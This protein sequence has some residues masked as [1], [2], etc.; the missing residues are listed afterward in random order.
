N[1]QLTHNVVVVAIFGGAVHG[2][3]RDT[4]G[5]HVHHAWADDAVP[6]DAALLGEVIM[7]RAEARQIL[8]RKAV[9]SVQRV[10]HPQIVASWQHVINPNGTLVRDVMFISSVAIVVAVNAGPDDSG[11][12]HHRSA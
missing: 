12:P 1:R 5:C 10:A 2:Q 8:R 11:L 3:T 6:A 9:L 7:E 4:Y